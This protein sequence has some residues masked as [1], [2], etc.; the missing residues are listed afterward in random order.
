MAAMK[1]DS[2]NRQREG[3][4]E[5]TAGGHQVLAAAVDSGS[6]DVCQPTMPSIKHSATST[7][8]EHL[9]RVVGEGAVGPA[10]LGDDLEVFG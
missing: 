4:G 9:D 6:P 7:G 3:K 5:T 2:P 8:V 1:S 10:V